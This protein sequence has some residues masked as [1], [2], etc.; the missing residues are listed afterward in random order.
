[1]TVDLRITMDTGGTIASIEAMLAAL[2]AV[3]EA[4][5]VAVA[6]IAERE[7]KDQLRRSSHPKGTP[8]PSAPGTPPALITGNLF[9]SISTVGPA[10]IAGYVSMQVGPTMIYSRIQELGGTTGRGHRS[11]LPARPYVQ[12]SVE[13]TIPQA[14]SVYLSAWGGLLGA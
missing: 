14:E 3:T 13:L 6:L 8:T 5:T 9:R 4:A 10:S 2:P 7:I 11:K 1:M 12:P